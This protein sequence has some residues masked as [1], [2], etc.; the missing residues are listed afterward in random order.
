MSDAIAIRKRLLNPPNG[1]HS[2]ET[3][4]L[5]P[6][7]WFRQRA[8][9]LDEAEREATIAPVEIVP[10]VTA[11]AEMLRLKGEWE[12]ALNAAQEAEKAAIR[13]EIEFIRA[14][15]SEFVPLKAIVIAVS[16]HYR[17]P[18]SE[19]ISERRTK[20]VATAR[21]M[22]MF[23]ARHRT[24]RSLP[25]IGRVLGGR[26]HTTILSGVRRMTARLAEEVKL[27]GDLAAICSVLGIQYPG[28]TDQSERRERPLG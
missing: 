13:S 6:T 19:M 15:S 22:V 24:P 17:I 18:I 7:I 11:E 26:D 23:I 20:D 9:K 14:A 1:R 25:Q 16:A 2:D 8:K 5:P 4:I 12:A 3:E 21:H 10:Q 28:V 27:R